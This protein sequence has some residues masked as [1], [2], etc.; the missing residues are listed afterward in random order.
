MGRM[1]ELS[2]EV[3]VAS[4]E[5][6][7]FYCPSCGKS[8]VIDARAVG[9]VVDCPACRK[10]VE[11]PSRSQ[12]A[13]P[14]AVYWPAEGSP[15]ERIGV[16]TKALEVAH[17]DIQRLSVHLSEVS[18]RRKYLEQLRATNI[19]SMEQIAEQ[20]SAIQSA[21]DAIARILRDSATEGPKN[22]AA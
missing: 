1:A 7:F 9:L 18:K 17:G 22:G 3:S 2:P 20:M 10:E 15:E 19:R 4:E 12:E 16:L 6:I 13:P 14:A 5:D 21:I 8:M 11:V